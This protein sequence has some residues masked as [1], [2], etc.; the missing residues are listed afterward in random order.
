MGMGMGD[1]EVCC[2]GDKLCVC[3]VEEVASVEY[4]EYLH[5]L[6]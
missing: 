3:S 6:S 4:L 1:T 5:P 2:R